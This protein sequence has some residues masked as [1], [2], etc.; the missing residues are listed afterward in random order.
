MNVQNPVSLAVGP[1]P[2]QMALNP[3]PSEA[4]RG[5][6]AN[7]WREAIR[8]ELDGLEAMDTWAVVDRP[9]NVRLVDSKLI[10]K[11]KT[12]PDGI[13][14]KF[15]ARLVARGFTQVAGI[16]FEETFAPVAP[17]TAIR[18]VFALAAANRWHIECT[19]F[20]QAYLNGQL[21][22]EVYMKPPAGANVPDG[23]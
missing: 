1:L 22:H 2:Q 16:D 7:H 23:K 14:M 18:T 19:D 13:P 17:Y 9:P 12:D 11:V 8:R 6:Q 15:K 3:S 10:L 4:L 5:P 20:T 21:E